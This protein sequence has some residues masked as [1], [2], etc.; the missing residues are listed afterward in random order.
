M[1]ECSVQLH[2]KAEQHVFLR[3]VD[4]SN[5]AHVKKIRGTQRPWASNRIQIPTTDVARRSLPLALALSVQPSITD[6]GASQRLRQA[7]M[8]NLEKFIK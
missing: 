4:V 6:C 8:G 3:D 5:G 2:I 7:F 1:G